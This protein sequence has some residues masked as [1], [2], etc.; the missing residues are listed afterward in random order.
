MTTY[1]RFIE[2]NEHEGETW[3]F[4]LQVDGNEE[5]LKLFAEQLDSAQKDR[6]DPPYELTGDTLGDHDVDVL[7]EYGGQGYMDLHTKVAGRLSI[8]DE[9]EHDLD[10]LYKGGIRD[11]FTGG[12]A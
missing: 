7:A 10:L 8:P 1:R 3:S 4:W 5:T 2:N 11:F 9:F 6:F 12:A